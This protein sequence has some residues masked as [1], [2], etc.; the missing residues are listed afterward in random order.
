MIRRFVI[1]RT[2]LGIT[3]A[4]LSGLAAGACHKWTNRDQQVL[5]TWLLCEECRS[6]ELD[7]LIVPQRRD[8]AVKL[9]ANALEGPRPDRMR[10]I[11]LQ[12]AQTY[13]R[14]VLTSGPLPITREQYVAHFVANYEADYESHAALALGKIATPEAALAL[15][16][17]LALAW[18]RPDVLNAIRTA[19][20][21]ALGARVQQLSRTLGLAAIVHVGEAVPGQ[22]LVTDSA[23]NPLA[24]V[25]ITF[26]VSSGRLAGAHQTTTSIGDAKFLWTLGVRPGADTLWT[27]VP[28][29]PA[30]AIRLNALPRLGPFISVL[31][32]DGQ[33]G[34]MGDTLS[35]FPTV[36]LTDGAGDPLA[37]HAIHFQVV[38]AATNR[39]V[40]TNAFGIASW[41][42]WVVRPGVNRLQAMAAGATPVVFTVAKP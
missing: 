36:Q 2:R 28:G 17:A 25:P 19:L 23:G 14:L 6:P 8:R 7:S 37:G 29:R 10:N 3:I 22:A 18:H 20:S 33:R 31:A 40:V 24:G 15:R 26:A 30:A 42:S 21:L 12:A 32:G 16:Q 39:T 9:L 11:G 34:R 38:G 13:Q 5:E 35:I 1:R 41:R 4:L 27:I